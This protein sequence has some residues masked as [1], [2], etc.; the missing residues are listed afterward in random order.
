MVP[1]MYRA[2]AHSPGLFATYV[3][4]YNRFRAQSGFTPAEQEVVLLTVSRF[5]ECSYCVAA[6]STLAD[7]ASGVPAEV[8]AAIRDDRPVADPRLGTL[9]VFTQVMLETGGRPTA[10]DVED[11]LNAGY[12]DQQ[13]LEIVLAIAVKTLSNYTN[14]LA[15]TPV[16][17]AFA[18][19]AWEPAAQVAG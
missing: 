10:G 7:T 3:D 13:V 1:N 5:N 16:D 9:S 2:M 19:R 6:H 15:A 4:G 11:F 14:H 8:T 12:T 17:E 18:G